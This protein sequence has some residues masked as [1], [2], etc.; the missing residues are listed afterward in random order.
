[1][2]FTSA[3]IYLDNYN[4]FTGPKIG[5]ETNKSI[6]L[7]D[8]LDVNASCHLKNDSPKLT[9]TSTYENDLDVAVSITLSTISTFYNFTPI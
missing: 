4:V 1:M 3:K 6:T 2:F 5:L 8:F 7:Q 9:L